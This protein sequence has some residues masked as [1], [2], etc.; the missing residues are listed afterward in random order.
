MNESRNDSAAGLK[1]KREL[2]EALNAVVLAWD[3]REP[4]GRVRDHALGGLLAQLFGCPLFIGEQHWL[5]LCEIWRSR[6]ARAPDAWLR[7]IWLMTLAQWLLY[8][9]ASGFAAGSLPDPEGPS[10]VHRVSSPFLGHPQP[11]S[12]DGPMALPFGFVRPG[13]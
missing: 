6:G 8:L 11:R 4:L 5:D 1:T 3:G 10:L 12:G 9:D 13:A 7:E 2:V